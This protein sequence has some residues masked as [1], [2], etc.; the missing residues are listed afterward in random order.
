LSQGSE[1]G[2]NVLSALI[3]LCGSTCSWP[4]CPEVYNLQFAHLEE[5]PILKIERDWEH[6]GR[7]TNDRARDILDHLDSYAILCAYHHVHFDRGER[8]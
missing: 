2:R 3:S 1:W 5:T 7:G 6:R 4:G 8:P